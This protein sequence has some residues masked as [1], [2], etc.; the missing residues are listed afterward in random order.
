MEVEN[1]RVLYD[2]E[3]VTALCQKEVEAHQDRIAEMNIEL[4]QIEN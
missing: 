3:K 1:K 2:I 4:R